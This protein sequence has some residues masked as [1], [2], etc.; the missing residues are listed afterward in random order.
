MLIS[1]CWVGDVCLVTDYAALLTELCEGGDLSQLLHLQKQRWHH[2]KE[3]S[4]PVWNGVQLEHRPSTDS[5]NADSEPQAAILQVPGLD[6]RLRLACQVA[7][8]IECKM[9]LLR[10]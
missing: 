6:V 4:F 5:P 1:H 3:H 9:S 10:I 8:A 7:Y 2:V